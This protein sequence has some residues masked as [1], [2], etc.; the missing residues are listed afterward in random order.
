M[1]DIGWRIYPGNYQMWLTQKN[2]NETS[3][4]LWRVE[5]QDQPYGRFARRFDTASGKTRMYFDIDDRFFFD[6]PLAGTY[7]VTLRVVYLD[8]GRGTWSA[9][10][11]AV[12]DP[13][14]TAFEV[15]NTD[16]GRWK[17]QVVTLDDGNFG[18]RADNDSDL[19]LAHVSGDDTTFHMIE[20][21]RTTGYR[22]TNLDNDAGGESNSPEP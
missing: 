7:P 18:N 12:A 17:E 1:N 16:T 13:D 14:K 8:K 19:V 10:Y 11:D 21:T 3:Q 5:P 15:T 22:T 20:L 6:Q 9:L 2:P 4:G